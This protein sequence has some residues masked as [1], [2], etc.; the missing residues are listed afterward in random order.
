LNS[1]L[2]RAVNAVADIPRGIEYMEVEIEP[3]MVQEKITLEE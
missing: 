3:A 2:E 1:C